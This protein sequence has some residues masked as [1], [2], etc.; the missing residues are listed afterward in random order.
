[1]NAGSHVDEMA[2]VV[3][4]R[5]SSMVWSFA[6]CATSDVTM[7]EHLIGRGQSLGPEVDVVFAPGELVPYDVNTPKCRSL[8]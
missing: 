1:M 5:S 4:N 8:S 7:A 6:L 2:Q 3:D